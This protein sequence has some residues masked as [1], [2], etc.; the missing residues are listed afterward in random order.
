MRITLMRH[1]QPDIPTKNRISAREFS[2]WIDRYNH[3]PLADHSQPSPAARTLAEDNPLIVCSH[4]LRSIN[5]AQR[6]GCPSVDY[7]YK[8]LGEMEMPY[9][10]LRGLKLSPRWWAIGFRMA[11]FV[12]YSRNCEDFSAAKQRAQ[13]GAAQL[14]KLAQQTQRRVLFIGHGLLNR[15]IAKELR[16]LGWRGPKNAGRRYWDFAHYEKNE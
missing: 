5:S 3:A 2:Q 16:A 14:I 15:F 11:W 6:L 7:S 4:L 12:G 10:E 13:A 9:G 1:G 8:Q